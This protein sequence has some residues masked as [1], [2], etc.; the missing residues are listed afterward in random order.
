MKITM[1]DGSVLEVSENELP[2]IIELMGWKLEPQAPPAPPTMAAMLQGAIEE[3]QEHEAVWGEDPTPA[4]IAR[5]LA[6]ARPTGGTATK[7]RPQRVWEEVTGDLHDPL[8]TREPPQPGLQHN[9]RVTPRKPKRW[10]HYVTPGEMGIIDVVRDFPEGIGTADIFSLL[11]G[12]K[13]IASCSQ[14]IHRLRVHDARPPLLEWA[15]NT[16]TYRLTQMARNS[17]LIVTRLPAYHY[18]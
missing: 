17:D 7:T 6:A 11:E 18:K 5:T 4:D 3:R 9:D 13:S 10:T 2:A 8:A 16:I 1:K 12:E 15:D 14:K